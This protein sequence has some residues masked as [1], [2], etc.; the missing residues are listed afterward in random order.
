M[1]RMPGRIAGE[2]VQLHNGKPGYV[3]TLQAREQHIRRE[4]ATSNICSNAALSA[5][6]AAVYLSL[7]GPLG[8]REVAAATARKAAYLRSRLEEIGIKPLSGAPYFREFA[9]DAVLP[10]AY[11]VPGGSLV[12]VTE[13]RT[14]SEI[15]AFVRRAEKEARR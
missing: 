11:P 15:D 2:T 10:G 13:K 7:L 6:R 12:A 5:L 3:L 1:R 14:R 9:V 4:K 8:L